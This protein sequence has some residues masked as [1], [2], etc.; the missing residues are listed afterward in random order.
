[1]NFDDVLV[2]VLMELIT[3]NLDTSIVGNYPGIYHKE[4]HDMFI[5]K[6]SAPPL[7]DY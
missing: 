1:M 4:L 7:L 3:K 5:K 6:L 2:N